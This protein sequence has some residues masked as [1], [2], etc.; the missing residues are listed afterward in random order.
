VSYCY[1]RKEAV[2]RKIPMRP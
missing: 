2:D 1:E